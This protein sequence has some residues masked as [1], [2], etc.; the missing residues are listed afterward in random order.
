[1]C[2]L[3]SQKSWR[4]G[5]TP[6]EAPTESSGVSPSPASARCRSDA[7]GKQES[8]QA[9]RIIRWHLTAG[10]WKSPTERERFNIG[11]CHIFQSTGNAFKKMSFSTKN[12]SRLRAELKNTPELEKP[13]AAVQNAHFKLVFHR[14]F[15][16]QCRIKLVIPC[17]LP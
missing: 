10:L 2:R 6:P 3:A 13:A 7:P 17:F 1:M 14:L 12:T 16:I 9:K 8:W 15:C 4:Q 5:R 11:L